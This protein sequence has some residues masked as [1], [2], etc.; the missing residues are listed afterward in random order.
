[1]GRG[2]VVK[3]DQVTMRV[4][5]RCRKQ[6]TLLRVENG[7]SGKSNGSLEWVKIVTCMSVI[8]RF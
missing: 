4:E 5:I 2:I 7:E 3:A 1:M 8:Y 6:S